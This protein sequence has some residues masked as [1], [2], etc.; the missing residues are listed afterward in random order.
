MFTQL[1]QKLWTAGGGGFPAR[2]GGNDTD[3]SRRIGVG[4]VDNGTRAQQLPSEHVQTGA[5]HRK[6]LAN[7]GQFDDKK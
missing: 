3:M 5:E 1:A 2:G 6:T 7:G 4:F